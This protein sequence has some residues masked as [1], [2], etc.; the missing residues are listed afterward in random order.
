M[1]EQLDTT[2][3]DGKLMLTMLSALS[4]FERD[5]IGK[6]WIWTQS[7]LLDS[8]EKLKKSLISS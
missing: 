1:K 3:A 5:I 8:L 6:E 4:Q 2:M 7:N